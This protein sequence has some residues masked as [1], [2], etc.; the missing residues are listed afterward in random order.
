MFW[1]C[2]LVHLKVKGKKNLDP[3]L[4]SFQIMICASTW[5]KNRNKDMGFMKFH[6]W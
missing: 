5:G 1:E 4:T 2:K 3:K 6:N